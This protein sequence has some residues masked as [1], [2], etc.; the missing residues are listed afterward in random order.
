MKK[1]HSQARAAGD[2]ISHGQKKANASVDSASNAGAALTEITASVT[3]ISNMNLQIATA[4]EQRSAVAVE[5]SE[6]VVSINAVADENAKASHN[7]A[8]SSENLAQIAAELQDVVS[9]FKY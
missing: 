8:S 6:N 5:I 4:F 3:T 9:H 1:L 7:L 2:V